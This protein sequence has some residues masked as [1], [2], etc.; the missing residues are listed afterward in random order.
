MIKYYLGR[1]LGAEDD[2]QIGRWNSYIARHQGQLNANPKSK[3]KDEWLKSKQG[4]LNWGWNWEQ[5]YA[6]E[7]RFKNAKRIAKIA[8][9][10]LGNKS[11]EKDIAIESFNLIPTYIHW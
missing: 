4:L 10:E 11:D 3:N 7:Q 9:V 8:G 1:R 5:P 6:E 2:W